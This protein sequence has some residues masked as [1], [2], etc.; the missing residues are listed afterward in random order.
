M[1]KTDELSD[2]SRKCYFKDEEYGFEYYVSRCKFKSH[3]PNLR[4]NNEELLDSP[5]RGPFILWVCDFV[6]DAEVG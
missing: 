4:K 2:K 5:L 1:V 3:N 6:F